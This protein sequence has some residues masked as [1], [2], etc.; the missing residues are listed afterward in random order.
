VEHLG[1][2]ILV[3]AEGGDPFVRHLAYQGIRLTKQGVGL[4]K[5]G[6]R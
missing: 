4:T 3:F 6:Y 1:K 2:T 5:V